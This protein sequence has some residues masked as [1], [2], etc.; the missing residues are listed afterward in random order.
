MGRRA[1]GGTWE[2]LVVRGRMIRFVG[3]PR[4]EDGGD[5][6]HGKEKKE[7]RAER[8]LKRSEV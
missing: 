1:V 4:S 2:G 7:K 5:S 6:A 8:E 3:M